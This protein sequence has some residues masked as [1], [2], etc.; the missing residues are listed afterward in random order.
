MSISQ[1]VAQLIN[2]Y[3][4]KNVLAQL[5]VVINFDKKVHEAKKG[6]GYLECKK[7]AEELTVS[8][9]YTFSMST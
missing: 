8:G 6:R 2:F 1:I 5:Y 3:I 7:R 9:I 4:Q